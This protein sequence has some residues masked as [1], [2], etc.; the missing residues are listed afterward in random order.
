MAGGDSRG[1]T[2]GRTISVFRPWRTGGRTDLHAVLHQ[3]GL[4][5]TRLITLQRSRL[6]L[7]DVHGNLIQAIIET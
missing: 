7:T 5:H 4:D 1:M 6:R 2:Y 3:L